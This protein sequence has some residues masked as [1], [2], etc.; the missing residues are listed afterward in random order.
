[1]EQTKLYYCE[2]IDS[3]TNIVC[4][5]STK[6]DNYCNNHKNRCEAIIIKGP[7]LGSKCNQTTKKANKYC[8]MHISRQTKELKVCEVCQAVHYTK[9]TVCSK[10]SRL[11]GQYVA[12]YAKESK[13]VRDLIKSLAPPPSNTPVVRSNYTMNKVVIKQAIDN[14]QNKLKEIDTS[15]D[16]LQI[17]QI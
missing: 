14:L 10:C 9:L 2:F 3:S 7:H 8:Y 12:Y 15:Q 17:D 6:I 5:K 1:M 4:G 13:Q 11:G 16:Q